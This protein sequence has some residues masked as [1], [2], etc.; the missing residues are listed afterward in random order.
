MTRAEEFAEIAPLIEQLQA[1]KNEY[2]SFSFGKY[3]TGHIYYD[4]YTESLGKTHSCTDFEAFMLLL[5]KTI[6]EYK[7]EF[8][9][10]NPFKGL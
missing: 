4:F 7:Q 2:V 8:T 10:H 6:E 1:I 5:K 9:Y 3:R